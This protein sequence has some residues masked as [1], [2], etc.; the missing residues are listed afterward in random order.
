V[1]LSIIGGVCPTGAYCPQGSILPVACG[2]GSYNA[3]VGGES[4]SACTTCP[5][6][7]YCEGSGTYT[8]I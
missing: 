8:H 2:A 4:L 5:P 1:A 3:R 7:F 6:A